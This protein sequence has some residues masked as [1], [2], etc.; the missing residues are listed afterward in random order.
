LGLEAGILVVMFLIK[1]AAIFLSR[2]FFSARFFAA[3][4]FFAA[5]GYIFA[6]GTLFMLFFA[7]RL[8][9]TTQLLDSLL[10]SVDAILLG[11]LHHL[12]LL[13][14]TAL[15][16]TELEITRLVY[17]NEYWSHCLILVEKIIG[18]Y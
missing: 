6:R 13:V 9:G 15:F 5:W 11:N 10:L 2:A 8:D 17:R 18:L 4:R 3:T 14:E 1:L 7:L 16:R 12:I